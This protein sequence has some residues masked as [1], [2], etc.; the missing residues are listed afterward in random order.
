[1]KVKPAVVRVGAAGVSGIV[2]ATIPILAVKGPSP[3]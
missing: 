2:A 1:M 3:M